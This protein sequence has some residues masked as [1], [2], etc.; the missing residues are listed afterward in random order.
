MPS[1]AWRGCKSRLDD[2]NVGEMVRLTVLRDKQRVEVP[3][4]LQPSAQ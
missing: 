4:R 3:V 2:Y 1:T